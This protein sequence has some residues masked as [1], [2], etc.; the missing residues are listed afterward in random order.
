MKRQLAFT[1]A[2]WLL[3]VKV[4]YLAKPKQDSLACKG[5]GARNI[6]LNTYVQTRYLHV[7]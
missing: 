1:T 4:Q 7:Q 2:P 3:A 5:R 6:Q